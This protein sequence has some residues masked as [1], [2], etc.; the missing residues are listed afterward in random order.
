MFDF[1][2]IIIDQY[3]T[4]LYVFGIIFDFF[5]IWGPIV[6]GITLWNTWMT[7]IRSEFI[8]NENY[9]LLEIDIPRDQDKSPLAMETVLSTLHQTGGEG[10]FIRK[11]WE[12]SV[13]PWF[14]LELVSIEGDVHF[15][16]WTR[17]FFQDI[18][19]NALYAQ[20]PDIE[21]HE[22]QD[23]TN[24]VKYDPATLNLWGCEFRLANN[25]AYPIKTYV[26]YGLDG[27]QREHEKVDPITSTI[28]QLGSLKQGE[29]MWIQILIQ[30]HKG[31]WKQRAQREVD[32]ILRRDPDT[33]VSRVEQPEGGMPMS[34]QLSNEEQGV[35]DS[36]LRSMSKKPFDCG[37]RG[38]YL[39]EEDR[40]RQRN[41]PGLVGAFRQYDSETLNGFKPTRGMTKFSYP[42]Q[43]INDIRKKQTRRALFEA[44]RRRS[45]FHPPY[46]RPPFVLN[47]E[48]IATLYHF[49]G[50]VS[51]TPT[52]KRIESKKAE[53]PSDL[54]S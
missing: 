5:P 40:F 34:A 32:N 48:E 53:P 29:Q 8:A 1:F 11:Y 6:L 45:Y 25:D 31:D 2:D 54:P 37:I 18:V 47:T 13:R 28:E 43:D 30:A 10:T 36:V 12:G 16:I 38:I 22:V 26:D 21:I 42:W 49:P 17:E 27:S 19:E 20:Y 35:A 44:Y 15:F 23:Y 51:Q 24:F 52:F 14:S 41:I 7:Y 39:A 46:K 3:R 50:R 33:K 4:V 9:I